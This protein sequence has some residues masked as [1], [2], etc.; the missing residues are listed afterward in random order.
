MPQMRLDPVIM[1]HVGLLARQ[2]AHDLN[3][4]LSSILGYSSMLT[5]KLPEGEAVHR[6]ASKIEEAG[7]EAGGSVERL[8]TF[9]RIWTN[10]ASK[11]PISAA[12]LCEEINRT[13]QGGFTTP[14]AEVTQEGG[15]G[16][17]QLNVDLRQLQLAFEALATNGCEA[18]EGDGPNRLTLSFAMVEPDALPAEP[19]APSPSGKWLQIKLGDPGKGMDA[20]TLEKAVEPGFT[21][22]A[23]SRRQGLGLPTTLGFLHAHQ[24]MMNIESHLGEGTTVSLWIPVRG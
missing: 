14:K 24:G 3:N 17:E 5:A 8:L 21:T 11:M 13:V 12:A 15:A 6:Y 1:S 23:G 2:V 20:E 10:P 9:G 22:H 18:Q 19:E 16:T 7:N 4:Y